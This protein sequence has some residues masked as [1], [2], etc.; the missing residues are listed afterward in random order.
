LRSKAKLG[1]LLGLVSPVLAIGVVAL[2]LFF[3][4]Y[5]YESGQSEGNFSSGTMSAFRF[6]LEEGNYAWFY[7]SGFVVV[8]CLIAALG[9]LTGRTVPIWACAIALWFLAG[10]GMMSIGLFIFPLAVVLF[11]SA[12]LLTVARYES[13]RA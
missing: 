7:W 12:T 13:R 4:T 8:V 10:L 2:M 5:G 6:A 9:A 3:P 1:K 11:A